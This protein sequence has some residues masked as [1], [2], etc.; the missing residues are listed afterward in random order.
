MSED[1]E[2]LIQIFRDLGANDPQGWARSQ[3]RE[4]IPQLHRFMFLQQAF[5]RGVQDEADTGWIDRLLAQSPSD[6]TPYAGQH[7]ALASLREKGAT[8]QELTD[9]VRCVQVEALFS[10]CYLL[11]GNME[12]EP[13]SVQWGLYG[14]DEEDEPALPI[15]G[16]HESV[17]QMDP[18]GREMRPRPKD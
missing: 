13:Q 16:L 1:L 10:F 7:R 8:D 15:G 11:E 5:A 2:R 4:G 14:L 17:L 12:G 18:T 6:D 9:L 3:T